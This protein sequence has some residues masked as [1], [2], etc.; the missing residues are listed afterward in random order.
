MFKNR[1]GVKEECICKKCDEH[2]KKG[3]MPP[4]AQENRLALNPRVEELQDLCTL[5]LMLVF[6]V[7]PFMSIV[8][9]HKGAQ[10]GFKGESVLVHADLR[11]AETPLPIPRDENCVIAL[12]LK[13][14]LSDRSYH[15][16]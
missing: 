1:F 4:Q 10:F 5:E 15:P 2:L 7:I 12:T 3:K 9:K 16:K 13:R 6:Q 14:H 8:P 11:K